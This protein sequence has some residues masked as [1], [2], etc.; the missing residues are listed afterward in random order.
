MSA[1]LDR[2]E[3]I[4][5]ENYHQ[6]MELAGKD[7]IKSQ[8]QAIKALILLKGERECSDQIARAQEALNKKKEEARE[9]KKKNIVIGAVIGVAVLAVIIVAAVMLSHRANAKI[10]GLS[11][12]LSG[13]WKQAG[14]VQTNDYDYKYVYYHLGDTS[15]QITLWHMT[16]YDDAK[17]AVS[18]YEDDYDYEVSEISDN[19]KNV[20]EA[21]LVGQT[22]GSLL[23]VYVSKGSKVYSVDIQT[24]DFDDDYSQATFTKDI[25][26]IKIE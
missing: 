2:C 15:K 11:L 14:D 23:S 5:D 19:I 10:D 1:E 12:K 26:T 18:Y 22:D 25:Q 8:E 24:S 16:G 17:D 13:D 4:I 9:K 20:D 6:A 21:Y 7:D 3:S